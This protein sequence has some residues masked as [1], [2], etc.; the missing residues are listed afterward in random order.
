M[1]EITLKAMLELVDK[2]TAPLKEIYGSSTQ[3]SKALQAQREEL[4]KLSRAQL[5]S[6]H[7]VN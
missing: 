2:A 1:S 6:R 7:F 4:K 3:T 5:T